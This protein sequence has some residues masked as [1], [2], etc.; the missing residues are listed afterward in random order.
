[1]AE[2][3][4]K[5]PSLE[6]HKKCVELAIFISWQ[7]TMGMSTLATNNYFHNYYCQPNQVEMESQAVR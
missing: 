3:I 4:I 1:M 7:V 6:R 2:V 5:L